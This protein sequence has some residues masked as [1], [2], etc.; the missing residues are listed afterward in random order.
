MPSTKEVDL[1]GVKKIDLVGVLESIN[2]LGV[3]CVV[4]GKGFGPRWFARR[5]SRIPSSRRPS[6]GS[7]NELLS[8]FRTVVLQEIAVKDGFLGGVGSSFAYQQRYKEMVSYCLCVLPRRI[9]RFI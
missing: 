2:N 3:V 4:R 5:L 8:V 6:P 1:S 7:E 9:I